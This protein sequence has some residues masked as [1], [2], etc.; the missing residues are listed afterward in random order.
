MYQWTKDIEILQDLLISISE[1]DK[2]TLPQEDGFDLKHAAWE[3]KPKQQK[4]N[5]ETRKIEL[6]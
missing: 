2:E 6:K 1:I 4:R 3:E 5:V